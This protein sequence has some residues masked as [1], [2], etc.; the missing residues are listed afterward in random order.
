MWSA[1]LVRGGRAVGGDAVLTDLLSVLIEVVPVKG[2]SL[3]IL[4]H[5]GAC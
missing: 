5:L 3:R 4:V 2:Y 1:K